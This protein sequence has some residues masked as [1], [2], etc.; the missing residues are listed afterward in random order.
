MEDEDRGVGTPWPLTF[1]CRSLAS[2]I[3][4]QASRSS[5]GTRIPTP[6]L[7]LLAHTLCLTLP[8]L[9]TACV[10]AETPPSPFPTNSGGERN[11]R[12]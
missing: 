1:C 7:V 5:K 9:P 11:D 4:A 12:R 10:V 3:W 8:T 2:S 6:P